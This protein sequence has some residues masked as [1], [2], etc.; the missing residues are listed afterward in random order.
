M[1]QLTNYSHLR[2]IGSRAYFVHA[3]LHNWN[4][5]DCRRILQNLVP[6]MKKGYSKLL[7]YEIVLPA[8]GAKP[9]QASVDLAILSV[10]S[11]GQRTEAAWRTMLEGVGLKVVKI[12]T[13]DTAIESVI[14]AELA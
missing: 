14:E 3:V 13:H 12:W 7:L 8:T 9:L 1:P 6:A 2:Q 10:L 11:A 5:T 4:D